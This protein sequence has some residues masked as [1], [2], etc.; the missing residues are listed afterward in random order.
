MH[1]S[2]VSFCTSSTCCCKRCCN[3][4]CYFHIKSVLQQDVQKVGYYIL[5]STH[6]PR[7]ENILFPL[8]IGKKLDICCNLCRSCSNS[9]KFYNSFLRRLSIVM[10]VDLFYNSYRYQSVE[11]GRKYNLVPAFLCNSFLPCHCTSTSCTEC[12][13]IFSGYIAKSNTILCVAFV[14]K[15][16][17]FFLLKT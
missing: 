1:S 16:T 4:P 3:K 5:R 6:T 17:Q 11:A 2:C 14:R 8:R 13:G 7:N 15:F 10:C 12:N 9:R